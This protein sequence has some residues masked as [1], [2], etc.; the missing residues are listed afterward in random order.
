MAA[1]ALNA[2]LRMHRPSLSK[3]DALAMVNT[4][5]TAEPKTAFQPL[6]PD[7]LS[8]AIPAFYIGRNKAGFWIAREAKGRSG[9]IFL[10]KASAIEFANAQSRPVKC[11]LIFPIEAFELDV[12]NGGNPLIAQLAHWTGRVRHLLTKSAGT[13]V[14]RK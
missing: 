8:A 10:L 1:I 2:E 14:L 12:E 13:Q 5:T 9:G 3:S 7:I 4:M 6:D 11:A